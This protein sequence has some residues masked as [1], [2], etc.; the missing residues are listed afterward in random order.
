MSSSKTENYFNTVQN[1]MSLAASFS[2]GAANVADVLSPFIPLISNITILVR[3]V[4]D[5][6]QAAEHNKR[7]CH[8]LL[9]RVNNAEYVAKDIHN[10][11]KEYEDDLKSKDFYIKFKGLVEVIK[12]IKIFISQVSQIKGIRKFVNANEIQ[13]EFER[14][15][16]EFDSTLRDI[17]F[18]ITIDLHTRIEVDSKRVKEDLDELKQYLD[19]I[20]AGITD[21]HQKINEKL[22]VIIAMNKAWQDERF[23]SADEIID[24]N[25]LI[26]SSEGKVRKGRNVE[27]K[28]L[29]SHG[30]LEVAAKTKSLSKE[31]NKN[32]KD[33]M[34]QVAILKKLKDC[35]HVIRFY[36]VAEGENSFILITEWAELGTLKEYYQ[37]YGPLDWPERIKIALDIARGLTFLHT[38][39]I[40]HHDIRSD[41]ILINEDRQ[42]KIANFQ[43]SRP[44]AEITNRMAPTLST[45][46]YMAPEK[47]KDKEK[48][49]TTRAEIY[50]FGVLL[51]EIAEE[52][53]PYEGMDDII[54]IRDYVLKSQTPLLFSNM[55]L[56]TKP[57]IQNTQNKWKK[58]V[59][60][61]TKH[62]PSLR[63]VL[64]DI[65]KDLYELYK[66]H[67]PQASPRLNSTHK[68][69]NSSSIIPLS[70]NP[71]IPDPDNCD[72]LALELDFL[73]L[74]NTLSVQDAINEYKSAT[75][76]QVKAYKAFKKHMELGDVLAKYY[77]GYNLYYDIVPDD[78]PLDKKERM[79]KA[80]AYFKAAAESEN[81]DA[82]LRYGHCL[83]AGEGVPK[84]ITEAIRYFQ[85]AADNGNITGMYNIGN[86]CY[87]ST[88]VHQDKTKG[89]RY[90]ILAALN[91]QPKAIEMCKKKGIELTENLD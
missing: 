29:T 48:E 83:W 22:E 14:L 53:I 66:P 34:T 30:Q 18:R 69:S 40:Y 67:K 60:D 54:K 45:V 71:R 12:R 5:L 68:K 42:P 1:T 88:G 28:I 20:G 58:L 7:I 59:L 80:A 43:L 51:W 33:L 63:P 75:G 85:I 26:D 46:R 70:L 23:F 2:K 49:Y 31:E 65:F 24:R 16:R 73:E 21:D 89:K 35:V 19:N 13:N 8:S 27:K 37:N 91:Q 10:R 41:N 50:S 3:E 57:E 62:D 78:P 84:N 47:L 9:E 90:L 76:D 38:V 52:K 4:V 87:N 82:Q 25:V 72:D 56:V 11:R 44:F 39:S 17:S 32:K 64:T 81:A 36:G 61:A 77:V 74:E 6:Y 86:I 15:T 55:G 79:E